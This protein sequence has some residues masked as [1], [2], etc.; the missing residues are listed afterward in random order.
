MMEQYKEGNTYS[1]EVKNAVRYGYLYRKES[2]ESNSSLKYCLPDASDVLLWLGNIILSGF[3]YEQI[4]VYAKK[5]LKWL[6]E[7][8]KKVDPETEAVLENEENLKV[9]CEYVVE[10][11][12]RRMSITKEQKEYIKEEIF[13]DFGSAKEVEIYIKEGRIATL[14]ERKV[15]YREAKIYAEKLTNK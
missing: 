6:K 13:A 14:E 11:S 8:Q 7:N 15:I 4:K 10:F 12:E 9:F 2:E 5:T 3:V 1:D